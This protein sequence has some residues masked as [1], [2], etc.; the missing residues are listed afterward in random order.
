MGAVLI[1]T[2]DESAG[3]TAEV[4]IHHSE[5]APAKVL[6]TLHDPQR[7][8]TPGEDEVYALKLTPERA[9]ELGTVLTGVART[10]RSCTARS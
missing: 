8:D 7:P 5:G 10:A 1:V 4:T 2:L 6:I 9:W 3:I